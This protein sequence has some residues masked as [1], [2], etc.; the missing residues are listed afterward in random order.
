VDGEGGRRSGN[1]LVGGGWG[2]VVAV[3]GVGVVVGAKDDWWLG[4]EPSSPS[5]RWQRRGPRPAAVTRMVGPAAASSEQ[6]WRAVKRK[7]G[8]VKREECTVSN[9]VDSFAECSRFGTR[10]IFLNLKIY[11]SK[12]PL[13]STRQRLFYFLKKTL[14]SVTWQRLLCQVFSSDNRQSIFFYFFHQTFYV[15]FLQYVDLHVQF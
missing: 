13:T 1:G 5:R 4:A 9:T 2:G 7:E 8:K 6:Q 11:F 14:L 3:G 12:C 10:Q 15:V